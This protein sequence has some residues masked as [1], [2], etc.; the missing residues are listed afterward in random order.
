MWQ[1]KGTGIRIGKFYPSISISTGEKCNVKLLILV[2]FK[3]QSG[4][5]STGI[6]KLNYN[7]MIDVVFSSKFE[8]V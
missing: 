4:K 8:K 1:K 7:P 3:Q 6:D 5:L 2:Y